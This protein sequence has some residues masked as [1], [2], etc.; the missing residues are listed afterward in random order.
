M[1]GSLTRSCARVWAP[2]AALEDHER[3]QASHGKASGWQGG[4]L[5]AQNHST[6]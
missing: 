2:R 1:Q 4:A 5:A 6:T 3:D